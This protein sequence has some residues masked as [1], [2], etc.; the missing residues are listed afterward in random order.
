MGGSSK[1][2]T[3]GYKYLL[4][5]H[6]VLCHGPVDH[7]ST[8]RVDQRVAWKGRSPG[9][10]I[11]INAPKLFGGEDREGGVSGDLDIDMGTDTQMPNDYLAAQLG[12]DTPAFR[13]V[14]S[15]VLRQMYLGMNP[16]LKPWSFRL[17]R[18]L[19][20]S[21]GTE[22]WFPERAP[23]P[24]HTEE[25]FSIC[26]C[27]DQSGSM[28]GEVRPGV[29][30]MDVQVAETAAAIR[31]LAAI[32]A[33][34]GGSIGVVGYGL[35]D[36][37]GNP[38]PQMFTRHGVGPADVEAAA[39]FVESLYTQPYS[40][41]DWAVGMAGARDFFQSAP[42]SFRR[43]VIFLTDGSPGRIGASKSQVVADT[44]A[45]RDAIGDVNVYGIF[46]DLDDT[47]GYLA[48]VDNTAEDGVPN[49][50]TEDSGVVEQAILAAL[51]SYIVYD[52]NP[53]HIVRECLVDDT[54]GMGYQEA[55]VDDVS[56]R[57]AAEQIY[58]ELLGCSILWDRQIPLED[59]VGEILKHMDAVLRVNRRTG[60]FELK[61]VRDDYDKET[62]LT[63]DPS[64]VQKIEGYSRPSFG[65]LVNSVTVNY[66]DSKTG[67]D[68]SLSVQDIALIATQGATIN[69]T[70]QYPGV[71]NQ[72][73]ASRVAGRDL[74][75]LSNPLVSCTLYCNQE[76]KDLGVGDVFKL[77]WPDYLVEEF[78][79]RV[80]SIAYGNGRS[81][82]I[83]IQA[84]QDIF[85]LPEAVLDDGEETSWEDPS[86]PPTPAEDRLVTE[87]TYF[88]LIQRKGNTQLTAEIAD[89]PELGYLIATAGRPSDAALNMSFLVDSGAGYEDT[90]V[91]DFCPVGKLSAAVGKF[92]TTMTLQDVKDGDLIEVG[93]WAYIGAELVAVSTWDEVTGELVVIRGILDTIPAT[94]AAG[95]AVFFAELYADGDETE[96]VD[97]DTINVKLLPVTGMGAVEAAAA[98]TDSLTID[99]RAIRPFRPADLR[100]F[101]ELDPSPSTFP[102]YP[103]TLSWVARNRLQETTTTYLSWTD[104]GVTPETGVDY[105]VRIEALDA[106]GNVEGMVGEVTVAASP[107][108]LEATYLG[109]QW[110]GSPFVRATVWARRDGW[111]SWQAPSVTFRGP[112][113]APVILFGEYRDP[114]APGNVTATLVP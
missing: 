95:T 52:M 85:S 5:L 82:R 50:S 91:L 57:A 61:L 31:A 28:L 88:D 74:K 67:G 16:Y 29:T 11:N 81:N 42:A 41:T 15:A 69:T 34:S 9:G 47:S 87:A 114:Q 68:A 26:F 94:H 84:A 102:T 105:V 3:V 24:S 25:G 33:A 101:G 60:K 63:L 8:I 86:Q 7:V 21:D 20:K 38:Q 55:D 113:R 49:V 73:T 93:T 1:K 23:I 39:Q 75:T 45:E 40:D 106:N 83:K 2:Q 79:M 27:I 12:S 70:V 13:G 107:Y 96:Y 89:V 48:Q 22:Q 110:S 58:A 62:L 100:A 76:A 6:L 66:W 65:E 30:R 99:A 4:G 80:T 17:Q 97:G 103:V 37:A 98:T 14:V 104:P 71:T 78:V 46:I 53:V 59:F 36:G 56:F 90:G 44:L 19:K 43:D 10:R 77:T 35:L 54:W 109:T 72:L 51:S 112:F 108:V 32:L 111:L 92:D 64:N 18:I